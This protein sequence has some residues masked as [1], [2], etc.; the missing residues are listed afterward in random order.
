MDVWRPC[1]TVET[2]RRVG[3]GDRAR[4]TARRA[5]LFTRQNVPFVRAR[6]GAV[7]AIA[8]GGYVLA[9]FAGDGARARSSSPP[10]RKSRSRS[11]RAT[12]SPKEGIA[13]ARRVDAVHAASS[14]ARTPRTARACCRAA[15]PRVAV[16]AGVT[17]CWRKYVG[18][19]D[20][21]RAAVVGIDRFGESAPARRAVQALRLHR[22]ARRRGG[23]R[24]AS[25]RDAP[26]GHA[27]AAPA[28]T[29]PGDRAR[30]HRRAGGRRYAASIP[31]AYLDGD[32]RRGEH[33]AVGAACSRRRA[34]VGSVFVAERRATASSASPPATGSRSPST[35]S[36]P[37]SSAV[38]LR[39]GRTSAPG[40]AA[41]SSAP[42]PPRSA[43]TAR[44]A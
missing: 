12:R 15:S 35:A 19:A 31:Q 18:A 8:R 9:D 6:R 42:S 22:R 26:S 25:R 43:R 17:D 16:E 24:G 39:R 7:A 27:C 34:D 37:S 21:P 1:D 23:P 36:M 5:L 20:D 10:A 33:G 41:G 28:P 29:T 3:G 30:A 2:A 14:T 32:E 38:Y 40:S 4:A 44:P 11:A 13:R